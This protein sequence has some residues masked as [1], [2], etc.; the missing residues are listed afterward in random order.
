MHTI[1]LSEEE[2]LWQVGHY[3]PATLQWR[4]MIEY[5]EESE[6]IRMVNYLN[7]GSGQAMKD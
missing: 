4:M 3:D 2:N 6:A 7:G 1:R 5:G